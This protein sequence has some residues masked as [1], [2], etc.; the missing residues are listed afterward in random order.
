MYSMF[1]GALSETKLLRQ[2]LKRI[3][4][5]A[6]PALPVVVVIMA[7]M[8]FACVGLGC[9]I[10]ANSL[11]YLIAMMVLIGALVAVLCIV[12]RLAAKGVIAFA[13]D[14][15]RTRS[16]L[17][18]IEADV[19]SGASEE[20]LGISVSTLVPR[21]YS[22]VA[23][24]L[25]VLDGVFSRSGVLR[26][27]LVRDAWFSMSLVKS[28]VFGTWE[29]VKE[30]IAKC[31][32]QMSGLKEGFGNVFGV[33]MGDGVVKN[34]GWKHLLNLIRSRRWAKLLVDAVKKR[35]LSVA[36]CGSVLWFRTV[37]CGWISLFY[38]Q[39]M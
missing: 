1:W 28:V 20:R 5:R 34:L 26:R 37:L 32:A 24:L 16:G 14:T 31:V 39:S 30:G 6:Y 11:G 10:V 17:Y 18:Q 38:C 19:K 22:R 33:F 7:L 12:S 3:A 2:L 9:R 23:R 25:E 4:E 35:C 27:C 15:A 21:G 8:L 13:L 29:N 36:R